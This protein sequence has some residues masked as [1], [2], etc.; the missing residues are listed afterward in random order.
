MGE[1]L[2]G[3]SWPRPN[4]LGSLICVFLVTCN[5]D[6]RSGDQKYVT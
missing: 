5:I 1:R 6:I 4:L 2:L 3:K